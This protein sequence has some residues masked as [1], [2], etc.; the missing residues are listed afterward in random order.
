M[1]LVPDTLVAAQDAAAKGF[2]LPES[3]VSI[4]AAVKA[5]TPANPIEAMMDEI[6]GAL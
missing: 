6:D 3:L 4:E 2:I 5:D 1:L